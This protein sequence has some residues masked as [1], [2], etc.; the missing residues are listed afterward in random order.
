MEKSVQEEEH[1]KKM[2]NKRSATIKKLPQKERE[3][4]EG[5][6]DAIEAA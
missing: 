6:I 2:S 4:V 5:V 1:I 3:K